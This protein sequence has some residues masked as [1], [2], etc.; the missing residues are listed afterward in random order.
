MDRNKGKKS[1]DKNSKKQLKGKKKK[2]AKARSEAQDGLDPSE[3]KELRNT[4]EFYARD[5]KRSRKPK[6]IRAVHENEGNLLGGK[7]KR[8]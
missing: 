4:A 2:V 1:Q 3:A 7:K 6:R 5:T 8:K